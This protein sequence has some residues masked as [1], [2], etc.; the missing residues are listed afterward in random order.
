MCYFNHQRVRFHR[1]RVKLV[2][3][4][5]DEL[6]VASTLDNSGS[7]LGLGEGGK[8]RPGYRIATE[9]LSKIYWGR[10]GVLL[11]LTAQL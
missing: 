6:N 4:R 11:S 1:A 10:G 7:G 3:R 2:S 9:G 8:I 5:G